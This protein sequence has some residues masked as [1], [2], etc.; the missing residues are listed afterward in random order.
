MPIYYNS[1]DLLIHPSFVEAFGL[2][3]IEAMACGK[4]VLA[5][6]IPPMNEVVINGVSGVL[7]KPSVESLAEALRNIVDNIKTLKPIGIRARYIAESRYSWQVISSMYSR[8]YT[9]LR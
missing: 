8:L 4:P 2:V 3:L 5:F 6:D 9:C 1:V 7:V